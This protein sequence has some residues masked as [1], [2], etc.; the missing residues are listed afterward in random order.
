MAYADAASTIARL[1]GTVGDDGLSTEQEKYVLRVHRVRCA[2]ALG[3]VRRAH[4]G[5][6]GNCAH[7]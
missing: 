3:G 5:W 6:P 2:S 4:C 7:T 1:G